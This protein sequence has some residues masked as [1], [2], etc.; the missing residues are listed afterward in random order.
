MAKED[1]EI[2]F[3]ACKD[4]I[5]KNIEIKCQ[6]YDFPFMKKKYFYE[7]EKIVG[8]LIYFDDTQTRWIMEGHYIGKDKYI[9]LKNWRNLFRDKNI[10][11][12]KLTAQKVNKKMINFYLKNKFF[13]NGEDYI[14]Y[15]FEFRR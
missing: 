4:I 11:C 13:I 10:N 7:D 5:K 3:E 1:A 15:Y 2:I 12:F 14:N 6:E 8:V 9:F